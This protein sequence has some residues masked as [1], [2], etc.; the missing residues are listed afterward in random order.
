MDCLLQSYP[1]KERKQILQLVKELQL[2]PAT[3]S[4]RLEVL[5]QEV[6]RNLKKELQDCLAFSITLDE[7]TDI[8][9]A[10]QLCI[11]MRYVSSSFEVKEELL[12]VSPLLQRTQGSDILKNFLD[13]VEKFELNLDKLASCITDGAAAMTGHQAGFIG[14]LLKH[15]GWTIP[16]FHCIIHQQSLCSKLKSTDELEEVM[17]HVVKIVDLIH[18][19]P[20]Q[21]R[22]FRA[23]LEEIE[24]NYS[25][26]PYFSNVQWLSRGAVLQRFVDLLQPIHDFLKEKG[27]KD[28]LGKLEN[29][30]WLC[31]LFFLNDLTRHLNDLNLQGNQSI[32]QSLFIKRKS[33]KLSKRC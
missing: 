32:N 2:S 17:S 15:L 24:A 12:F 26:I 21:H 8:G 23:L 33:A 29:E 9:D 14:L 5:S 19:K 10:A 6:E 30:V 28:L 13:S 4:S 1:E 27:K 16:A 7:S 22:Q 3:V 31:D 18:S 11:W 25:D 20:L